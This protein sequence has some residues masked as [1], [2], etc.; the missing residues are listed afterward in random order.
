M[1]SG[2]TKDGT[3]KVTGGNWTFSNENMYP[4]SLSTVLEHGSLLGHQSKGLGADGRAGHQ[5]DGD[6]SQRSGVVNAHDCFKNRAD[7]VD[8]CLLAAGIPD[9]CVQDVPPVQNQD[10]YVDFGGLQTMLC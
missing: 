7:G 8:V 2:C 3:T 5:A 10:E 1:D 4:P 6:A 9:S